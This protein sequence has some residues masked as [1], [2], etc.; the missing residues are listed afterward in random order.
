STKPKREYVGV[1]GDMVGAWSALRDK[2]TKVEAAQGGE[3]APAA[4]A[5]ASAP[6]GTPSAPEAGG[7]AKPAPGE[8]L[9]FDFMKEEAPAAG[10]AASPQASAPAAPAEKEPDRSGDRSPEEAEKARERQTLK[11]SIMGGRGRKHKG[12]F[13]ELEEMMEDTTP[14]EAA[15]KRT[16]GRR[17]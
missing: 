5:A 8:Q 12:V 6:A 4:G 1:V 9:Q 10:G 7:E 13:E 3:Q 2:G 14:E 11:E 15:Q 17:R 16:Q